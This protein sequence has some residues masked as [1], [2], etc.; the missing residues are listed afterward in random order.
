MCHKLL[1]RAASA[2]IHHINSIS[3]ERIRL[4]IQGQNQLDN[5]DIKISRLIS[6]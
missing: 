2:P 4:Q 6:N 1:F 5:F 3:I